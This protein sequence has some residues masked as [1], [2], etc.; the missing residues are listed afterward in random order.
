[1][2]KDIHIRFIFTCSDIY[3]CVCACVFLHLSVSVDRYLYLYIY[4]LHAV[5]IMFVA[6]PAPISICTY[7]RLYTLYLICF[8]P[9]LY[10]SISLY[11]LFFTHLYLLHPY[12]YVCHYCT[13]VSFS[14]YN[15]IC[16]SVRIYMFIYVFVSIPIYVHVFPN[17]CVYTYT[18]MNLYIG[19]CTYLCLYSPIYR[20]SPGGDSTLRCGRH[21]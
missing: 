16:V 13:T 14:I 10:Q 8:A 7:R 12:L 1:M 21:C 19:I 18:C 9:F 4:I 20:H 17:M 11:A 15:S 6:K 2:L 5:I 3:V